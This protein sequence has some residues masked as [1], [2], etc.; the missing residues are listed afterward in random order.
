MKKVAL[1]AMTLS[2]TNA[3]NKCEGSEP[4][5]SVAWYTADTCD[6]TTLATDIEYPN[7]LVGGNQ[8]SSWNKAFGSG[9]LCWKAN[10][11]KSYTVEC[12]DT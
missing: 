5:S 11:I 1:A 6:D 9:Q 3:Q 8:K 7:L 12:S 4:I 2:M 10:D